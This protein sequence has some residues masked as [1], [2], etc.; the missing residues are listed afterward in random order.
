M[1]SA[2]TSR[3]R[4]KKAKLENFGSTSQRRWVFLLQNR[5][6]PLFASDFPL[7]FHNYS[8]VLH[9]STLKLLADFSC[10]PHLPK[11]FPNLLL[12]KIPRAPPRLW[13]SSRNSALWPSSSPGRARLKLG[14]RPLKV[15]KRVNWL[16]TLV[17]WFWNRELYYLYN[18]IDF[19]L[20]DYYSIL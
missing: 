2:S 12:Q 3:E 1:G 18:P 8:H 19:P 11:I 15:A 17:D 5:W 10:I 7:Y 14:L 6:F 16:T 20:G 9:V 4:P 13:K